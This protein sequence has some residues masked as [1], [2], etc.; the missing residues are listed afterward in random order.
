MKHRAARGT[1][2]ANHNFGRG[3]VHSSRED[4][5]TRSI[6]DWVISREIEKVHARGLLPVTVSRYELTSDGA[7]GGAAVPIELY[8]TTSPWSSRAS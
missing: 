3:A 5:D 4:T 1:Q 7:A 2:D 6:L 8:H